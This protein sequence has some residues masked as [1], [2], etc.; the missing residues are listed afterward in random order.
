MGWTI[1][2]L[3]EVGGK[4]G[5]FV[6]NHL[7]KGGKATYTDVSKGKTY[8]MFKLLLTDVIEQ[9]KLAGMDSGFPTL[10]LQEMQ[11]TIGTRPLLQPKL[12]IQLTFLPNILC[13]N[14]GVRSTAWFL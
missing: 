11:K 1:N 10:C 13:L 9:G 14:Q 8:N 7:V 4:G 6:H 2:K 5:S 12:E 3:A